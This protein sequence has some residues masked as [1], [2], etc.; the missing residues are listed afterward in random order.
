MQLFPVKIVSPAKLVF[1][2]NVEQVEVPGREGDFGVLAKHAP[3]FS[4]LRAGV[5]TVHL[6]GDGKKRFFVTSGYAEVSPESTVILSDHIE[7]ID[8]IDV[9][10]ARDAYETAK[11]AY[12]EA[13]DDATRNK[14]GRRVEAARALLDA[15]HG[16]NKH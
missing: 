11:A 2:A 14:L 9:N 5:I 12:R 13:T 6:A 4:M 16:R 3:F 7:E 8:F 10:E 15:V 1:D